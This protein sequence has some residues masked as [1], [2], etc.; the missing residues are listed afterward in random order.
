MCVMI[1]IEWRGVE[2]VLCI[3]FSS[4]LVWDVLGGRLGWPLGGHGGSMDLVVGC[5]VLSYGHGSQF[6][7]VI[8]TVDVPSVA[9]HCISRCVHPH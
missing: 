8:R 7:W 9:L 5:G 3:F 6:G 2:W 4:I 1:V